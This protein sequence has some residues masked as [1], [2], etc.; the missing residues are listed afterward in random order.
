[1]ANPQRG[2][3]ELTFGGKVLRFW[4]GTAALI[5]CQESLAKPDGSVPSM[6]EIMAGVLA[7]RRV[8]YTRAFLWGGLRKFH[9]EYTLEMVDELID[10]AD[11]AE[12]GG[13]LRKLGATAIPDP[14]D[15][16]ALKAT[17]GGKGRKGANPPAAQRRTSGTGGG[18][19][20]RLG[21]AD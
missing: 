11:A 5:A 17:P 12:I 16:E 14:K 15:A 8:L 6:V 3:F 1:V 4:T 21:A 9:P 18:S 20:S 10:S 19:T 2:E 13:L 7:G